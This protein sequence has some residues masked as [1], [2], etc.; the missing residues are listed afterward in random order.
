MTSPDP[1]SA[2]RR[3]RGLL[4][5]LTL[6][7][8]LASAQVNTEA[9][10][11]RFGEP[12]WHGDAH[13]AFALRDGNSESLN[14][15]AGF[16]LQKATPFA[17]YS[18]EEQDFRS[19]RRLFFLVADYAREEQSDERSVNQGFGHL[20][21]THMVE[22]VWGW[23]TFLQVEYDE[24]TRL[25]RRVLLG[26]G[27]RWAV[28]ET[29]QRVFHLGTGLMA[30]SER[31]DAVAGAAPRET[32]DVVR[33]TSYATLVW[34]FGVEGRAA[35]RST[36]YVQPRVDDVEDLRILEE[37]ALDVA[38]TQRLSLGLSLVVEHDNRP[39]AGVERTDLYLTNRLRV[40]F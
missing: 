16:R 8:A 6:L 27:L 38:L 20:R 13:L 17:S 1:P 31:L 35:L 29:P 12:G 26:A 4:V 23:E 14:L 22:A 11:A 34:R 2:P 10:R 37:A 9:Y 33:S 18:E 28:D 24:F 15:G 36:L 40:S 30:E 3:Y 5:A 39:P 19:P 32:S 25:D 7:P 21:F